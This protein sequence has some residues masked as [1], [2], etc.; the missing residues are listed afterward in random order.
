MALKSPMWWN[1]VKSGIVPMFL[2][3][4]FRVLFTLKSYFCGITALLESQ[5]NMLCVYLDMYGEHL[6][7]SI[8]CS[9]VLWWI[10][11]VTF[12]FVQVGAFLP[13]WRLRELL[14]PLSKRTVGM[15][16]LRLILS[17]KFHCILLY[18]VSKAK[19]ILFHPL[20]HCLLW[21]FLL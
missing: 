13:Y 4:S 2:F 14:T 9:W 3:N 18:I 10:L 1:H 8:N 16:Q 19:M 11:E 5:I 12:K 15:H 20:I 6:L 21:L 17:Q 7:F